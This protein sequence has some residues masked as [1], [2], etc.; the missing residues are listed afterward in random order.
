MKLTVNQKLG[1]SVGGALL[2][3]GVMGWQAY[4]NIR[5]QAVAVRW[6]VHTHTVLARLSTLHQLASMTAAGSRTFLRTGHIEDLQQAHRFALS[7]ANEIQTIRLLASSNSE[8]QRRLSHLELTVQDCATAIQRALELTRAADLSAA[9]QL[10]ESSGLRNLQMNF[11]QLTA[12][13]ASEEGQRLRE[14]S[15]QAGRCANLAAIWVV[16]GTLMALAA[17]GFAVWQW[18]RRQSGQGD[19]EKALSCTTDELEKRVAARTVEINNTNVALQAEIQERQRIDEAL[20]QA[21]SE[22]EKRVEQ[23][24][25]ELAQANEELQ[26]EIAERRRIA[27]A[28]KN[29]RALYHS[30]VES[31]PVNVWRTDLEGRFT[32]GNEHLCDCLGVSQEDFLG[33]T[34]AD[35]YVATT[36]EK[37]LSDDRRVLESGDPFED[38]EEFVTHAGQ[39]GYQQVLKTP[40]YDAQGEVT[41]VQGVSWN[42]TE[43]KEAEQE[44]RRIQA[45]LEQMN[46]DLRAKN[47]EIQ[48]FYHTLSHE[49]KTPLT[50]AREFVSIVIDGLAGPLN[51][52][53]REYLDIARESCNQMRVCINDL[54]DATRLETGKLSIEPKPASLGALVERVVAAM[55]PIAV[56]RKISLSTIVDS[57]LPDIPLDENRILQVTNNLLANALKFT[58]E[59]GSVSVAV[60]EAPEQP[61]FLQVSVADTGRGIAREELDR[62][63]DRLYQVKAGDAAAGQG[64]GLGLYLCRELV[65]LHGGCI[66]VQSQPGKGSIFRVL[67]PKKSPV[68]R[69]NLLLVDDDPNLREILRQLLERA[70]FTVATADGGNAALELMQR[71]KPDLV[72][73]DLVMPGLDGA[74]TLK[75]IRDRWGGVPVI[76]HTGFPEGELIE[77][78]RES[79]PFTLLPKPCPPQRLISTALE[80]IHQN[81]TPLA[82]SQN[83]GDEPGLLSA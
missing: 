48:N 49:L 33:K 25:Q 36:V 55:Q 62:I 26:R 42:V 18:K 31:L 47:E 19:S 32:F 72:V 50:S 60:T 59:G 67:L 45:Q 58:P 76:L 41:G 81:D 8:Q 3:I 22:L 34:M 61:E 40:Y 38:I 9:R 4:H 71:H 21:H 75:K 65:L 82:A 54:L 24:T 30:L 17:L 11:H 2:L 70:H 78:A 53:Q 77:R 57:D 28:L 63:F 44:M 51:E 74:S 10:V 12:E 35:F 7:A 23:R 66:E 20:H 80:L 43:R 46:R 79:S 15:A 64:I 1:W 29:S 5:E 37:F 68:Q 73:L 69:C 83:G 52:T 16:L 39:H 6:V 56:E 27:E 13:V 14:R